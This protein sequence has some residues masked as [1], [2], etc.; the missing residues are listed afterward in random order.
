MTHVHCDCAECKRDREL[1]DSI[2]DLLPLLVVMARAQ[3]MAST[4]M[5]N[6]WR[7]LEGETVFRKVTEGRKAQPVTN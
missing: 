5:S 7:E 3:A 2:R 1:L 6:K 4:T